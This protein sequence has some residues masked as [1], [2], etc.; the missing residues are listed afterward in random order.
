MTASKMFKNLFSDP[1]G[2]LG[3]SPQLSNI[4]AD[5]V[6]ESLVG[7]SS[8]R[9]GQIQDAVLEAYS[10]SLAA[11][12]SPVAAVVDGL[13][14]DPSPI[15]EAFVLGQMALAQLVTA[16]HQ[17]HKI[18]SGMRQVL[19]D[20]TT[21]LF[22]KALYFGPLNNKSLAIKVNQSDENVSRRLKKLRQLGITS[23][24]KIGTAVENFLTAGVRGLIEDLDLYGF[25][26]PGAPGIQPDA[27]AALESQISKLPLPMQKFS[28]FGTSSLRRLA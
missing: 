4:L 5:L 14:T 12:S 25:N 6:E 16:Q 3:L 17:Q 2:I 1:T 22:V 19:K 23:S 18:C 24:R 10:I 21:A 15:A 11:C 7:S 26:S 20:E 28:T 9:S 13:D 8:S 27:K